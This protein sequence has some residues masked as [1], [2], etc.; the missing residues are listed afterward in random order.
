M[1]S[2]P[3]YE[4]AEQ[5]IRLIQ[6]LQSSRL[7]MTLDEM[8]EFVG[9]SRRSAER[10]RDAI[11]RLYDGL[12]ERADEQRVKRWRITGARAI[13]ATASQ[14]Q[15]QALEVAA[16]LCKQHAMDQQAEAIFSLEQLLK[17]QLR[18][19]H[20]AKLEPDLEALTLAE[21]IAMRPVPHESYAQAILEPLRNAILS[22]QQVKLRYHS[23]LS[24]K[25]S[26]QTLHPYGFLYGERGYLV[27]YSPYA[28][29][30][31]YFR[32]SGIK[33]IKILDLSFVYDSEFSL[34]DY[35][36]Q[37]F[38]VFQEEVYDVVLRFEAEVADDAIT[39]RFHPSQ[40]LTRLA[41]SSIEVRFSAGGL[42]EMCWH[43]FRWGEHVNILKPGALK[44]RMVA[45][46]QKA[47]KPLSRS[48]DHN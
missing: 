34:H 19:E 6:A 29:D 1:S 24:G 15:L 26:T 9:V 39:F 30:Y 5:L 14:S 31:R 28:K 41:D 33:W 2:A 3:R 46:L 45:W 37:S 10:M 18:P 44:E 48:I 12:E 27:A 8:A 11:G 42:D 23:K 22:L 40:Q 35:A 20:L 13:H 32:L 7:G 43:L 4:T 21:G 16:Q 17:G 25:T 47:N 36:A 38:G